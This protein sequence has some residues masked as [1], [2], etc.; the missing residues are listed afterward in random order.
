M[1]IKS[2]RL[3]EQGSVLSP[4]LESPSTCHLCTGKPYQADVQQSAN[5]QRPNEVFGQLGHNLGRDIRW[6]RH[7]RTNVKLVVVEQIFPGA[8]SPGRV[9]IQVKGG[10]VKGKV[11]NVI[12][13]RLRLYNKL[14]WMQEQ[15]HAARGM[16]DRYRSSW[17]SSN[18]SI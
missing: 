12:L 2:L 14:I 5:N 11:A 1:L 6:R 13:E 16:I 17:K 8:S 18:V 9:E 3:H 15:S 4:I 10:R 7:S